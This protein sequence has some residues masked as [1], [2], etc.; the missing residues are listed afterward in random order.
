[1]PDTDMGRCQPPKAV[2]EDIVMETPRYLCYWRNAYKRKLEIELNVT[3]L[4]LY[5]LLTLSYAF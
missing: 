5:K 3:L 1:L 2:N 4:S